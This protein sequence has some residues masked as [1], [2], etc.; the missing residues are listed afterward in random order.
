MNKLYVTL[1][2]LQARVLMLQFVQLLEHLRNLCIPSMLQ[3]ARLK[4]CS[5]YH[6]QICRAPGSGLVGFGVRVSSPGL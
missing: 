2:S 4:R 5:Q 3:F 6:L 1:S